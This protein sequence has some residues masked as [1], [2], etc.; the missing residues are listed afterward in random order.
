MYAD[1]TSLSYRS[2]DVNQL[3]VAMSKD[4]TSVFEW[5]MGNKLS[6]NVAKTNAMVM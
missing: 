3:N 6:L 2:D 5:L 4:L 1:D